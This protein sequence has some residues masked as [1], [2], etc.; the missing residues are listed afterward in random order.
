MAYVTT[1]TVK[2]TRIL[3]SID[4]EVRPGEARRGEDTAVEKVMAVHAEPQY[5]V[6][7]RRAGRIVVDGP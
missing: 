6:K 5:F 3:Q 2:A 7:A 1:T 4:S